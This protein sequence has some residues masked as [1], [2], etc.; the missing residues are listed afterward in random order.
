MVDSRRRRIHRG[1]GFVLRRLGAADLIFARSC[2]DIHSTRD[3]LSAAGV[4]VSEVTTQPWGTYI[5]ATDPDENKVMITQ[6]R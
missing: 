6:H 2:D 1:G 4:D 3:Q 5:T